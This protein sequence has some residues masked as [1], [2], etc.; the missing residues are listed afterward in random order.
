[1][2]GFLTNK[3]GPQ[4]RQVTFRK[5]FEPSEK[6]IGHNAVQNAIADKL[7]A[8]IMGCAKT[9]MSQR[10]SKQQR[11]GKVMADPLFERLDIAR[12]FAHSL[13]ALEEPE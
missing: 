9:A 5:L 1:M 2:Q 3:I 12:K 11:I 13:A 8:L 4:T 6:K 7:K 10:C